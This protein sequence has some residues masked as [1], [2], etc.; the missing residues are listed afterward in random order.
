MLVLRLAVSRLVCAIPKLSHAT[1]Q[2]CRCKLQSS[3]LSWLVLIHMN[4]LANSHDL[5]AVIGLF[6]AHLLTF[7]A[8]MQ[9]HAQVIQ[10]KRD[11]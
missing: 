9:Q 7:A 3:A 8:V 1:E 10:E 5:H 11:P 6:L 2:Q 4:D